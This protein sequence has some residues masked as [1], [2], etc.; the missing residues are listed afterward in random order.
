MTVSETVEREEREERQSEVVDRTRTRTDAREPVRDPALS[1]SLVV[2]LM[3]VLSG[4]MVDILTTGFGLLAVLAV[5]AGVWV[6]NRVHESLHS[7]RD[8]PYSL[9]KGMPDPEASRCPVCGDS[10]ET[11]TDVRMTVDVP[12]R[13]AYAAEDVGPVKTTYYTV[14]RGRTGVP[15][16]ADYCSPECLDRA[17][18]GTPWADSSDP[19]LNDYHDDSLRDQY[20]RGDIT[21]EEFERRFEPGDDE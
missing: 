1:W 7:R 5:A 11:G 20:V 21:L 18:T 14:L 19:D 6:S 12:S 17:V 15:L 4:V 8:Y 3:T 2:G 10:V 16:R 13:D 9:P